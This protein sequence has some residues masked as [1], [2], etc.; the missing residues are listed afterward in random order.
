ME[1][2]KQIEHSHSPLPIGANQQYAWKERTYVVPNPSRKGIQWKASALQ[3][4]QRLDKKTHASQPVMVVVPALYNYMPAEVLALGWLNEIDSLATIRQRIMQTAKL[5]GW[6]VFTFHTRHNLDSFFDTAI[7]A[8]RETWLYEGALS[9]DAIAQTR[10]RFGPAYEYHRI[11]ARLVENLLI[12]SSLMD[13][14]TVRAADRPLRFHVIG[15]G[16]LSALVWSGALSYPE[17]VRTAVKIGIRW[18]ESLKALALEDLKR[19]GMAQ[20]EENL[21]WRR[22]H[23]VRQIVEGRANLSLP[24]TSEDLPRVEGPSR[25]FWFSATGKDEPVRIETV[26]EVRAALEAMNLAS[27]SPDIPKTQAHDQT[28][29][30]VRGWLVSPMH[31]AASACHWSVYNYLLATPDAATLFLEHIASRGPVTPLPIPST[32]FER[33]PTATYPSVRT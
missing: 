32:V 25:P 28:A 12:Q 1:P 29:D 31:P 10:Q 33:R 20:T 4:L 27:W 21:G 16:L 24:V 8:V 2:F 6:D 15:T 9:S 17:V 23:R 30:R 22:F 14:L 3:G 13:W 7:K 18:D 26:Q 5:I 19:S 11:E